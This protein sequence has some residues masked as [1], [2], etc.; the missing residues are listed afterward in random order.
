MSDEG[1]LFLPC[2]AGVETLL[3][4][5]IASLQPGLAAHGARGGV[6]LTGPR[7]LAMQLNLE[8]RLAQR[9]LWRVAEGRYRSEH[10]LYALAHAVRWHDWITPKQTLRVDTTARNAPVKSLNFASLRIKDAV[11]DAMREH[12][13]ARPD[14]D[15]RDPDL[16][17]VLHLDGN[18]A[19]LYVDTSGA[20]LFKRG[21]RDSRAG[22]AP[23]KETLAAAMLAAAGWRGRADD[24]A[25]LDPCCGAGTIAIE[26]AQL[27]CGRA[28][29]LERRFAFERLAPFRAHQE[30]WRELLG[31]ARARVQTSPVP[32]FAGDV[33]FRMTDFA[34][35]HA[36]RAGVA[37]AIQFKAGDALQRPPPLAAGTMMLNPP[38]GERI[39]PKGRGS[40][41]LPAREQ[42]QGAPDMPSFFAALAA[43]W[44]RHYAGWTGW[45]LSPDMKL[46][47]HMRLRESRR[48]PLWNGPIECRLFRFDIVAG[49]A[50]K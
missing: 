44:K 24:G 28:P 39:V 49:A 15:I 36:E 38:Y 19:T 33:S 48:V 22:D 4:E 9:V 16:S 32:V 11:C 25:L 3:A 29:G 18:L 40:A 2:A 34:A 27:A 41:A 46:P 23:L 10:D 45:I 21:W 42:A 35:R 12:A 43:Q 37:Q 31:A 8:S 14:V 50:R 5:E 20:P 6:A 30:H 7:E 47:T 26:A 13:G 1:R 17:L